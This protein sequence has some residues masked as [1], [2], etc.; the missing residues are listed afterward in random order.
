MA[1]ELLRF[2]RMN[3]GLPWAQARLGNAVRG[4]GHS[5]LSA[6][7]WERGM[8]VKSSAPIRGH[9]REHGLPQGRPVLRAS[10]TNSGKV[11][12][13]GSEAASPM[14]DYLISCLTGSGALSPSLTDLRKP[15]MA[16]PR[17]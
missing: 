5:G 3:H 8:P 13:G 16:P 7:L 4:H 1:G 6:S 10:T 17:S 11:A 15:L 9:V 12:T 2:C 14:P